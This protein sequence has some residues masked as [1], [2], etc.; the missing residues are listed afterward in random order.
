MINKVVTKYHYSE[1]KDLKKKI[2]YV[3]PVLNCNCNSHLTSRKS[4]NSW[5]LVKIGGLGRGGPNKGT[6]SAENT[7]NL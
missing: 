4:L 5:W 3:K 6:E 1:C 2:F 7:F